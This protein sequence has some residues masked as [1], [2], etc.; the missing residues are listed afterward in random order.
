[1]IEQEYLKKLQEIIRKIRIGEGKS[2][3]EELMELY[4][5]KPVRLLWNVAYGEWLAAKQKHLEG[6][7]RVSKY[8]W[9]GFDYPGV[10][11]AEEFH[12]EIL[13]YLQRTSDIK[14]LD[15][16]YG[17]KDT[18]IRIEKHLEQ[19]FSN[20]AQEDSLENLR[21][22]MIEYYET[23]NWLVFLLIRMKLCKE[24]YIKENNKEKWY[25]KQPNYDYLEQ[26]ILYE[27]GSVILI[28]DDECLKECD[29]LS[30]ILHEFGHKVYL[31]T[32][33]VQMETEMIH[34]ES[35]AQVCIE[36]QQS[37]E[38][39][40]V[41][42]V[43]EAVNTEGIKEN[44][45]AE[46]IRYL[47]ENVIQEKFALV[48][49]TGVAFS[50]LLEQPI[51]QKNIECLSEFSHI[52]QKDKMRFGWAGDYTR[53][54]SDIYGFDV[55]KSLEDATEYDFSIV[56][57]ARNSAGTLYYTLQTCLNQD[58][59]GNYEII[60]SDNSTD[61]RQEVYQVCKDLNDSR[62]HYVKTP[63]NLSLT[64]SFEFAFL[65]ARGEFIFS[66]GSDDGVCPWALSVLNSVLKENPNQ[67]VAQWKRG[68]Y[69]WK[70]YKTGQEHEMI[71]P[72]QYVPDKIDTT[73]EKN[74]DYFVRLFNDIQWMY[75]L[76]NLY[77]NSGFRR[78]FLKTLLKKTGR[79]WDGC[80]QDLYMGVICAAVNE[81]VI[82][83]DFPLTIAGISNNSLGYLMGKP[84]NLSTSQT[85]NNIRKSSFRGDN[86]GI[87]IVNGITREIP[88]GTGEVFSLYTN[89]LRAIQLGV[90]PL[91]WQTELIDD[92]KIFV[93]FFK[94]H[95]CL[96]DNFDKYLHYARYLA[97]KKGE[98]FLKWFDETIYKPSII[99]RKYVEKKPQDEIVR[100]YK[101]GPTPTGGLIIDASK[102]GVT[103]IAE[104]V[105]LFSELVYWTPETYEKELEK[106]R[107]ND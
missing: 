57:P 7:N 50:H 2:V 12:R 78:S 22:L 8:Y 34:T 103:N 95:N 100:S 13:T 3:Q 71:I 52:N 60:V 36:N 37:Y 11:E 39:A 80:N 72:G 61:G 107:I 98:E 44:N 45:Q 91:S 105:K 92:K 9:G 86:R 40:V 28:Q 59:K 101:E 6:W 14:M 85:E 19:V 77:I 42:P 73:L 64:K 62:I 32:L 75:S 33:P 81:T 63:G 87:Y 90:L 26:K 68:F 15:Y 56:I 38:D 54:I 66:L 58:Y 74:I 53:Y 70:G 23:E 96:D 65:Q 4:N 106:R 17:D 48:F 30:G 29:L 67:E 102:Y 99:P 10:K 21:K 94:E 69:G 82:N 84:Q 27:K 16:R 79:L 24:G 35:L 1:M 83:I 55:K 97:E 76:P 5:Y 25:Y 41:I 31:L 18:R 49:T 20:Y 43:I 47:Y 88:I 93:E 46:I 104:A 89:L 51:L